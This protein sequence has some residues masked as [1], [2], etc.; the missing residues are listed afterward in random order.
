M[1]ARKEL[2]GTI[3]CSVTLQSN[4]NLVLYHPAIDPQTHMPKRIYEDS[5]FTTLKQI[6]QLK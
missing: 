2:L 6:Y 1:E 5:Q 3:A 4:K